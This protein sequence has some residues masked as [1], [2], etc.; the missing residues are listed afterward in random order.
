M[1]MKKTNILF[2]TIILNQLLY[3]GI[4]N[5]IIIPFCN[6]EENYKEPL[7]DHELIAT[8]TSFNGLITKINS[9]K[10]SFKIKNINEGEYNINTVIKK[11][12]N[13]LDIVSTEMNIPLERI[14][15][16][17]IADIG[18][19][20][21]LIH[22]NLDKIIYNTENNF[23]KIFSNQ[24]KINILTENEKEEEYYPI[25]K[26]TASI[27][28]N[29]NLISESIEVIQEGSIKYQLN[30]FFNLNDIESLIKCQFLEII[31][32]LMRASFNIKIIEESNQKTLE[33]KYKNF[34]TNKKEHEKENRKYTT[35]IGI[36]DTQY[37]GI[38]DNKNNLFWEYVMKYLIPLHLTNKNNNPIAILQINKAEI[39][40]K[41][42]CISLPTK[43]SKTI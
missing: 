12:L 27:E 31:M 2:I 26:E 37:E 15:K 29:N 3:G 32:T 28:N 5:F 24:N 4:K 21:N 14:Q 34:I 6:N 23:W 41:A 42:T 25:I 7:N 40:N 1:T 43:E 38:F 10:K 20:Q 22:K 35:H 17:I 39:N 18:Y 30:N 19:P 9:N 11:S 36:Y 16:Y 13:L 8:L 33:L